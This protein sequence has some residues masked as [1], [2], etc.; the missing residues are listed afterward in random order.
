M[1]NIN[2]MLLE[3]AND[4]FAHSRPAAGRRDSVRKPTRNARREAAVSE[5]DERCPAKPVIHRY[6]DGR[7]Y[8]KPRPH[9]AYREGVSV[10]DWRRSMAIVDLHEPSMTWRRVFRAI[11]RELKLIHYRDP[12]RSSYRSVLMSFAR[13]VGRPPSAVTSEHVREYLEYLIDGGQKRSTVAVHLSALRTMLDKLCFT[14]LTLGISTPRSGKHLPI[15]LS[16]EEVKRL[17][18][19]AVSLRDK[20]LLG[21][22]YACGLRVSEVAKLRWRDVDVDR[23]LITVFHGKGDVDRQ[24]MLPKAYRELL[25]RLKQER[26]DAFLFPSEDPTSRGASRFLSVRTIQ[27]VM[28]RTCKLAEISKAATPHSLRHSFATHSFEDGCDIRRIQKALGHTSLDTTTIYLKSARLEESQMP[29]P[30]DA[31]GIEAAKSPQMEAFW[32][33][34]SVHRKQF[35]GESFERLTVEIRVR[36]G[37]CFLTGIRIEEVRPGF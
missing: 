4:R 17:L 5:I 10:M 15:V 26:G 2:R 8:S 25:R 9:R 35:E 34:V 13:W 33:R 14:D 12:T 16:K 29:S 18:E 28:K 32:S 23:N 7:A 1:L 21:L 30:I 11:F 3:A 22:M 19:S 31:L 37:R 36:G 20:L 24:V 27:R 6:R